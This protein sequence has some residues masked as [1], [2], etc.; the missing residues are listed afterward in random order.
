[1]PPMNRVV[2]ASV[3]SLFVIALLASGVYFYQRY[4]IILENPIKAVPADAAFIIET[5]HP[6]AAL[7]EFFSSDSEKKF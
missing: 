3:I 4:S 1:M 6:A 5:K 2:V 7:K